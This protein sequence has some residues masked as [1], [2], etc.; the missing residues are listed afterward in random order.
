MSVPVTLSDL[1]KLTRGLIHNEGPILSGGSTYIRSYRLTQNDQIWHGNTLS[2]CLSRGQSRL[3][4]TGRDPSVPTF[5]GA[6]TCTYTV[7]ESATKTCMVIKD[8]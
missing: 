3:H 1:E 8:D 2:G 5:L 7:K 4:H 6:L